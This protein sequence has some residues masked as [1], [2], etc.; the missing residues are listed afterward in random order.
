MSFENVHS[1]LQKGESKAGLA[2]TNQMKLVKTFSLFPQ[3]RH[4]IF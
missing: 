3:F 2:F 1:G 4:D